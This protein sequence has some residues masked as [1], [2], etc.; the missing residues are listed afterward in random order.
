MEEDFIYCR[1]RTPAGIKVEEISGGGERS[2][3]VWRAMA[4]QV[5]KENGRDGYRAIDHT[6]SGAP[7]LYEG[8]ERISVTHTAHLLAVAT[9]APTPGID[10]EHFNP[11]TA[12]GIDAEE[13]GRSQV[14]KVRPRFLSEAEQAA[15][16]EDS[17]EENILAWTVKEAV[18]KAALQPGLDLR[19]ISI[20]SLPAIAADFDQREVRFGEASAVTEGYGRVQFQLYSYRS[21]DCIVTLAWT[22]ES[23]VFRMR[24]MK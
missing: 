4:M 13:T 14:L 9:L 1:H 6:G 7:L 3:A 20:E 11:R 23:E 12:L 8:D 10:L 15:I 24:G 16:P 22:A 19:D 18:Y 17:V 21:S 5:Y 2:G